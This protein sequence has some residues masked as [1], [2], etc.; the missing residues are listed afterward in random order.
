MVDSVASG[1]PT[2][3][4]ARPFELAPPRPQCP[5]LFF[6][7]RRVRPTFLSPGQGSQ[8]GSAPSAQSGPAPA[9]GARRSAAGPL[10][11][12]QRGWAWAPPA[13]APP[14]KGSGRGVSPTRG[15]GSGL[16]CQG[17]SG[18][19]G[20]RRPRARGPA[21]RRAGALPRRPPRVARGSGSGQGGDARRGELRPASAARRGVARTWLS[22]QHQAVAADA[23]LPSTPCSRRR[24]RRQPRVS[25]MWAFPGVACAGAG[26]CGGFQAAPLGPGARAPDSWSPARPAARLLP[27]ARVSVACGLQG[28]GE[29]SRSRDTARARRGDVGS[30]SKGR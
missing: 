6:P 3:A 4:S 15:A 23:I 29:W 12:R 17:E 10:D 24:R 14:T 27:R 5:G 9:G 11:P 20:Q 13:T 18:A 19:P 28:P 21:P 1:P 30:T 22:P 7:R 25:R 26:D 2:A 8:L 16:T